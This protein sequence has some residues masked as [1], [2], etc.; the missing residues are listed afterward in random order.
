MNT[1]ITHSIKVGTFPKKSDD[2][3]RLLTCID[4]KDTLVKLRNMKC[5]EQ[6]VFKGFSTLEGQIRNWNI[7]S[8]RLARHAQDC[9]PTLN[10]L[11]SIWLQKHFPFYEQLASDIHIESIEV[12]VIK[13]HAKLGRDSTARDLVLCALYMDTREEIQLSLT[14]G[15][16]EGLIDSSSPLNAK[17][18]LT[19][20][21]TELQRANKDNGDLKA[22]QD[23][24][25]AHVASLQTAF[26]ELREQAETQRAELLDAQNRQ[27]I[28]EKQRDSVAQEKDELQS[29]REQGLLRN[30]E[31]QRFVDELKVSLKVVIANHNETEAEL[32]YQL[33][34]AQQV[35]EREQK[36]KTDLS[37]S[38]VS[39]KITIQEAEDWQNTALKVQNEEQ[40]RR[41]DTE[42][43]LKLVSDDLRN[44]NKTLLD[45]EQSIVKLIGEKQQLQQQLTQLEADLQE[46]FR[47]ITEKEQELQTSTQLLQ[48]DENWDIA[49]HKIA[50]QINLNLPIHASLHHIVQAEDKWNDWQNWQQQERI[51]VHSLLSLQ[52]PSSTGLSNAESAQKLLAIRWYLLEWIRL[53]ILKTLQANNRAID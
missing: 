37:H 19:I 11:V 9:E 51:F 13:Q 47:M 36:A 15:L 33:S 6:P 48:F 2:I 14:N 18:E 1:E 3:E 30:I 25:N 44:A 7:I 40:V 27:G 34:E 42:K 24:L 10:T 5:L 32:R 4:H 35:I 50:Q 31:L 38:L 23:R 53:K 39:L 52:K 28:I 26:Q 29:E 12:D 22:E 17:I 8:K 41:I 49:I 20:L 46:A 16:R 45:K 43:K 21:Q